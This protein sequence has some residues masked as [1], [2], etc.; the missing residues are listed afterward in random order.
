[1][2]RY[3]FYL[4]PLLVATSLI[5]AE[6]SAFGAGDINSAN[7][8]GLTENEKQ[9]LNVKK[10]IEDV[11]VHVKTIDN[12]INTVNEQ[13][14]GMR[15]VFDGLN[16]KIQNID[17]SIKLLNGNNN[18]TLSSLV[19]EMQELKNYMDKS[20]E[21]ESTNNEN[22]KKTLKD[23]TANIEKNYVS[24][25]SFSALE[26]RILALESKKPTSDASIFSKMDNAEVLKV[27]EELFAEKKY[28][29]AKP[30]FEYL[31]SKNYRPAR[32]NFV[33]GEIEY[34]A[35]NHSKAIPYYKKSAE[36]Y[37]DAAWM[38]KLMYHTAISFDKIKDKENADQFY[39]ALKET[40]PNS[41]E[42]KVSPNR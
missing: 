30:Y 17:Q 15:S 8:Y 2:K 25:S 22:I 40:F 39:K 9:I 12:Q 38:P 20:R 23:L 11:D 1:M 10:H 34:F 41:E 31:L 13:I 37:Q 19:S 6:P 42:A 26:A 16:S 18:E 27:G 33:L 7:P 4:L 28:A 14:D 24:K 3:S 29:D 5:N 35:E 32:S 36:L 21:I